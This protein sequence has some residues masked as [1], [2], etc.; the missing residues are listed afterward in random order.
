[1]TSSKINKRI[2]VV[3]DDNDILEVIEEILTYEGFE[4]RSLGDINNIFPEISSYSPDVIILDY[5]LK[6]INGGEICHQIKVNPHTAK[7]PVILMSAYHR[8]FNSL[9]NYGCNA[10]IAKPFNLNDIV[11]HIHHLISSSQNVTHVR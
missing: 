8:V 2:L 10:F 3:D 9:G 6:G 7:V 5:I 4:V 11:D 1:M